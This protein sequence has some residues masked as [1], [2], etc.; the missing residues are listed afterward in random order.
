[1]NLV[2]HYEMY[3]KAVIEG[4]LDE[5]SWYAKQ[6]KTKDGSTVYDWLNA[7]VEEVKTA[8]KADRKNAY[9]AAVEAHQSGLMDLYAAMVTDH[10]WDYRQ[11]GPQQLLDLIDE[12]GT[13][14]FKHAK[15]HVKISVD[16]ANGT[17]TPMILAPRYVYP[18]LSMATSGSAV[19]F[20]ADELDFM[21]L[22]MHLAKA[23]FMHKL[24]NPEM[25]IFGENNDGKFRG[26]LT[27]KPWLAN[28]EYAVNDWTAPLFIRVEDMQ[29]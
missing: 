10:L 6:I 17:K 14:W 12:Q 22:N 15:Q 28:T 19:V 9:R 5:G 20:D 29:G 16:M 11:C 23:M 3:R 27:Q 4:A 7:K 2:K 21:R 18:W 26:F 13:N 1:M 25:K 8:A 24:T